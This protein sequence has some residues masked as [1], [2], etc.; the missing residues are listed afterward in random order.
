MV[1]KIFYLKDVN[2]V[3]RNYIHILL[4][5][6][7]TKRYLKKDM[8]THLVQTCDSEMLDAHAATRSVVYKD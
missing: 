3:N 6:L 7:N 2:Y 8:N 4:N 1:V 5:D